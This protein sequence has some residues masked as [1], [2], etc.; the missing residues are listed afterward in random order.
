MGLNE[1]P[2]TRRDRQDL[3]SEVIQELG[4]RYDVGCK[5][6][7]MAIEIRDKLFGPR[8]EPVREEA[9]VVPPPQDNLSAVLSSGLGAI[10][11]LHNETLEIL[12]E[13]LQK[14]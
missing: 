2:A 14:L 3:R 6:R 7:G 9:K 1:A 13:I 4:A 12:S 10:R 11:L 5:V 8:P